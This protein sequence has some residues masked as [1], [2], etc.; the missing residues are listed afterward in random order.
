[1]NSIGTQ[2]IVS[3]AV[4]VM[5]IRDFWLCRL[6]TRCYPLSR[7]ARVFDQGVDGLVDDFHD[8]HRLAVRRNDVRVRYSLSVVLA[9]KDNSLIMSI[10]KIPQ[11]P[12]SLWTRAFIV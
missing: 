10:Q 11:G 7:Y 2:R 8:V 6:G 3:S 4:L 9:S 12:R 5:T 1:M